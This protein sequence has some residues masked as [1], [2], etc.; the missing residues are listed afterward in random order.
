MGKKKICH[1]NYGKKKTIP[2]HRS[3]QRLAV[4]TDRWMRVTSVRCICVSKWDECVLAAD[5]EMCAFIYLFIFNHGKRSHLSSGERGVTVSVIRMENWLNDASHASW[6][7]KKKTEPTGAC[8]WSKCWIWHGAWPG[9]SVERD[10][11]YT[12]RPQVALCWSWRFTK[13]S[14]LQWKLHIVHF[15]IFF[16]TLYWPMYSLNLAFPLASRWGRHVPSR[17]LVTD[18]NDP[19]YPDWTGLFTDLTPSKMP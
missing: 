1:C 3:W 2:Y 12:S 6:F 5:G 13:Y 16:C 18:P 15:A 17:R 10:A 4:L 9:H 14:F 8:M 11:L 19:S 7:K